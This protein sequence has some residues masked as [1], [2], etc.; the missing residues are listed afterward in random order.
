MHLKT[1]IIGAGSIGNHLAQAARRL[2]WEVTVVDKDPEALRRMKEEIYPK[3]YGGWDENIKLVTSQDEPKGGF[4]LICVGTPPDSHLKLA[5]SALKE[6]PKILQIEKPLCTP[7]LEELDIFLK[8][9]EAQNQTMAVVGY[10][11]TVSKSIRE[12]LNL[13]E[14]NLIGEVET[15]DVEFREHW[16]GIFS[17]HPWLKGPHDTYLGF[18][19]RGGGVAGEHSHA[20]HLWQLLAKHA[21]LGEPISMNSA[22]EIKKSNGTE[23]DSLAAFTF[24][25]D[26]S[27]IGRVIQDVI[28]LPVRKWARLQ[29]EK[30]FIEWIANGDPKGD[31]IKYASGGREPMVKVFGKKRPDDFFEEMLHITDLLEKR[32]AEADSPLSLASAVK[33]M[34]IISLAHANRN[35]TVNL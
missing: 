8:E 10:D 12:V 27:K 18:W 6:K 23:Y 35:Q 33:V 20:L 19:S 16:Q 21:R 4:D 1:K 17:A 24:K 11:H 28:T 32:V 7:S 15:I 9:Y 34:K 30:G 13:L 22:M 5:L 25:T 29:G 2:G 26:R 14:Q 31:V 3:R